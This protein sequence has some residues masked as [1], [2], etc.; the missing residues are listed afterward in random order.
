MKDIFTGYGTQQFFSSNTLKMSHS[1]L[2][3]TFSDENSMSK[4]CSP[5]CN[6]SFVLWLLS[7]F[8]NIYLCCIAIWLSCVCACFS[9][10]LSCWRFPELHESLN[11]W[12]SINLCKYFLPHQYLPSFGDFMDIKQEKTKKAKCVSSHTLQ[13]TGIP[14]S[15]FSCQKG[16]VF[17]EVLLPDPLLSFALGSPLGQSWMVREERKLQISVLL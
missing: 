5:T 10:S 9:L 14:F 4:F 3:S 2:A 6:M 16:R 1:L 12:L 13:L 8:K 15:R 17:S 7:R 11:L